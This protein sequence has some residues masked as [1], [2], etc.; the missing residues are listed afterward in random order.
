MHSLI[1]LVESEH[2]AESDGAYL[3]TF[4]SRKD[5]S[6]QLGMPNLS[7]SVSPAEGQFAVVLDCGDYGWASRLQLEFFL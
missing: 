5:F 2:V 1:A 7:R 6:N 4:L 3:K